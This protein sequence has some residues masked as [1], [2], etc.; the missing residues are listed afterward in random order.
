M[1]FVKTFSVQRKCFKQMKIASTGVKMFEKRLFSIS[2]PNSCL[3][4]LKNLIPDVE[5]HFYQLILQF[6]D[7]FYFI[8][9]LFSHFCSI[10]HHFSFSKHFHERELRFHQMKVQSIVVDLT[11]ACFKAHLLMNCKI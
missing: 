5:F 2:C 3:L 1:F 4:S 11:S 10:K 7:G 8:K 9:A 6:K